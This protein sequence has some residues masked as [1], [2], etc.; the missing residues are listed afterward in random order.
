MLTVDL[1]KKLETLLADLALK[2]HRSEDYYVRL[3]LE[4]FFEDKKDY[5]IASQRLEE[6]EK[7]NDEG[8]PF[9]DVVRKHKLDE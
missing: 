3:A 5:L 8:I 1:P 7:E 6:M 2:T 9:E 4:G